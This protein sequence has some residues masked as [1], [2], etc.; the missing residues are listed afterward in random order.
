[1][2]ICGFSSF[3]FQGRCTTWKWMKTH[4]QN[5]SIFAGCIGILQALEK[6]QNGAGL[7]KKSQILL[8]DE[9]SK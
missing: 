2:L 1:M 7:L 6:C 5:T 3:P 8:N 4:A 9:V